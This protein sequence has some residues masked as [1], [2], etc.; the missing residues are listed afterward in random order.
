MM[1]WV[2]KRWF[3]I[4]HGKSKET[5]H[6]R[7]HLAHYA[8]L[9]QKGIPV[10]IFQ[11]PSPVSAMAWLQTASVSNVFYPYQISLVNLVRQAFTVLRSTA[12]IQS[13]SP[14]LWSTGYARERFQ[15]AIFQYREHTVD[16]LKCCAWNQLGGFLAP[17]RRNQQI[18]GT[19]NHQGR[20]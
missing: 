7:A 14:V 6:C 9:P 3:L 2:A 1:F 20:H 12:P 15:Q 11:R 19:V 16:Q 10:K 5:L 17:C 4:T 18:A 13:T 8:S